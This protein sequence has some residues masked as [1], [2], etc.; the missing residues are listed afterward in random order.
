MK[1]ATYNSNS[2]SFGTGKEI[3]STFEF[4]QDNAVNRSEKIDTNGMVKSFLGM[5]YFAAL[6][7]SIFILLT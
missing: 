5:V 2:I 1:I 6:M 4:T 3:H 7:Y